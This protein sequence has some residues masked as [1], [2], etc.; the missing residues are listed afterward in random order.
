MAKVGFWLNGAK[1]K[2][3]DSVLQKGESGTVIRQRVTPTNPQTAR[4]MLQR[5]AFATM[6]NAA[7]FMLPIIGQT[8][9]GA[10]N[11]TKNRRAFIKV[12]VNR[13][14]ALYNA[15]IEAQ[16]AGTVANLENVG[17]ANP[18][19]YKTLI[20]NPYII[21]Q[22]SLLLP[23]A[24]VITKNDNDMYEYYENT[25]SISAGTYSANR[26]WTMLFGLVAGQQLTWVGIINRANA[27]S[28]G[29]P[30]PWL[31][32]DYKLRQGRLI[33]SRLVL[34][35]SGDNI[36]ITSS[37]EASDIV[38][39]LLSLIDNE[40][41]DS[42][43]AAYLT[44]AIGTESATDAVNVTISTGLF[45]GEFLADIVDNSQYYLAAQGFILSELTNDQ[46]AY[47]NSE[48]VCRNSLAGVVQGAYG[49]VYDVAYPSYVKTSE[50][51]SDLYTRQGGDDDVL[52]E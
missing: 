43:W 32:P 4:Q 44:E 6:A 3:A 30:G 29:R 16:K 8:F 27:D 52:G 47:S 39:C 13:L 10:G 24:F 12:N 11:E 2:L 42:R 18:K 17:Y 1:G 26:L 7:K 41:S 31:G 34:K 37:T 20:P 45:M 15:Y 19:G 48:L 14:K 49:T 22:G 50:T 25:Q 5:V 46:W 33:A 36:T 9:E 35:S 23:S 21:A 38:T 28:A 51:S 40:K